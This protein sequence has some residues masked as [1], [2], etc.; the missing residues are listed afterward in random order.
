MT[1]LTITKVNST[2]YSGQ[3]GMTNKVGIQAQEYGDKW[4][5]GFINNVD[6]QAG[7]TI[8]AEV[9]Q[10]G[11]YLN[12]RYKGKQQAVG[13]APV[14]NSSNLT[15]K[16]A[17]LTLEK[18]NWDAISW[19]KCKHAYLVEAFKRGDDLNDAE[20]IAEEW[21]NASMRKLGQPVART[22]NRNNPDELTV[23]QIPY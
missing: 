13:G 6:F 1:T 8:F 18:P 17:N 2:P 10:K 19:G 9:E 7:D 3:Y 21:A 4:L 11:N 22:L 5:N 14:P 20:P 23:D 15:P 12:F 16:T